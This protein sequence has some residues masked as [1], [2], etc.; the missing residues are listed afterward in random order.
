MKTGGMDWLVG[1]LVSVGVAGHEVWGM[2][3]EVGVMSSCV[4][5]LRVGMLGFACSVVLRE[6]CE[7]DCSVARRCC[8]AFVRLARLLLPVRNRSIMGCAPPFYISI[9]D[10]L[11]TPC[12]CIGTH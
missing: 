10:M 5:F 12:H 11:V 9:Q 2:V 3:L 6:Q 8:C 7:K 4:T 1:W